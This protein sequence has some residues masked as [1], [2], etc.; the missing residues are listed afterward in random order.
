M[1][2]VLEHIL[3]LYSHMLFFNH[4]PVYY[5]LIKKKHNRFNNTNV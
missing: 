1:L 2:K 5:F 3:T 4:T